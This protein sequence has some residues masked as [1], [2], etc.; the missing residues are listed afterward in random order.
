MT[1]PIEPA[2]TSA[3]RREARQDDTSVPLGVRL[4]AQ[5]RRHGFGTWSALVAS[6]PAVTPY[7]LVGP[8]P[9]HRDVVPP[10]ASREFQGDE[11][12]L[13]RSCLDQFATD[14]REMDLGMPGADDFDAVAA[15]TRYAPNM[16]GFSGWVTKPRLRDGFT[17]EE[18]EA[19][20]S[21]GAAIA[22]TLSR[23]VVASR[24]LAQDIMDRDAMG[25]AFAGFGFLVDVREGR[26][27]RVSVR[28]M[29]H[30]VYWELRADVGCHLRIT[31][32]PCHPPIEPVDLVG[33][34]RLV[35]DA[36]GI[37]NVDPRAMGFMP[38]GPARRRREPCSFAYENWHLDTGLVR[39][40]E[41]RIA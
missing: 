10:S 26:L 15:L 41:C 36:A 12:R 13:M 21:Q 18:S 20:Y 6:D 29:Q 22:E 32:A 9:H 34:E 38:F 23:T 37:Q 27:H 1:R 8:A 16:R 11:A 24:Q 17:P 14:L 19:S 31:V 39:G 30:S 3:M 40:I 2:F 7:D 5:A 4:D 25:R 35:A 28:L 33:A